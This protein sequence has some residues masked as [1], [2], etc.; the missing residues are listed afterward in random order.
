MTGLLTVFKMVFVW[1]G[2]SF[3]TAIRVPA[4]ARLDIWGNDNR[5]LVGFLAGRYLKD[6]RA[7]PGCSAWGGHHMKS[8]LPREPRWILP[9]I[10]I[11]SDTLWMEPHE[12]SSVEE[13]YFPR[14]L[15][16]VPSDNPIC[17]A[18]DPNGVSQ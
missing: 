14:P 9:G 6:R 10:G 1:V 11:R 15:D 2:M 5:R 13:F 7:H 17:G 3:S 18:V 12:C 4:I 16:Q 8:S